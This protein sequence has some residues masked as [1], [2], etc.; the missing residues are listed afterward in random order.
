MMSIRNIASVSAFFFALA[1]NAG[2]ADTQWPMYNSGYNSQRYAALDQVNPHNVA[3]LR[4]LCRVRVDQAGSFQSGILL[5]D[6]LLYVT[7]ATATMAI[8]STDCAVAWKNVYTPAGKQTFPVNRG[9]VVADGHLYRGTTDC[10]L[11][12]MD[13]KTGRELW[14]IQACDPDAGEWLPAAPLVWD[15]RLYIGIAGGDWGVRGRVYAFD[16][17]NGKEVWRFNTVPAA[18]EFGADTWKGVS[19][20]T[21]GGGTWSSYTLDPQTG[22]LFIPVGNAA[23]DF[24][25]DPRTG[26]NLFTNSLVVLDARTGALRWWYQI[27]HHDDK[28]LDLGAPP[29][30]LTLPTGRAAVAL[31]SKDGH[32]YLLDRAIHKLLWRTAVTTILNQD[33]RVTEQGL[34]VCPG[35]VGGVEWNGPSYDPVN[36]AIIVGAVDW[37][38]IIKK[39]KGLDHKRGEPYFGGTY[40]LLQDPKPT[41]W[42]TSVDQDTGRV[43][44]RFHADAPVVSGITATSGGLVFAGDIGGNLYALES[45]DGTLRF[46]ENT[47]GAIAGGV[48][49]YLINDSQFIAVTSG[50]V[51]RAVWGETGLPYVVIYRLSRPDAVDKSANETSG[52]HPNVPIS[53]PPMSTEFD[54]QRGA[55]IYGRVCTSCHASNGS[56]MIGPPLVDIGKSKTIAEIAQWIMDPKAAAPPRT[57]A[58]PRLYPSTLSD[59]Q[60]WDVAAFVHQL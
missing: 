27:S 11:L 21:G 15:G 43:R 25:V 39:G 35:I 37:C 41:G 34:R 16:I 24:L 6:G 7:S 30:L 45:R 56:G 23:P 42:I 29:M 4:E 36:D 12:A 17:S 28:D 54:A 48:I 1:L 57:S 19:A 32:L 26:D 49:T 40:E 51:S 10:R 58:M 22:E 2:A 13:A 18:P 14:S 55:A 3:S 46:K 59:Q 38:A 47:R 5:V 9:A 52:E 50:N 8:D 33:K 31:A 20:Q 53:P 44:W 60:V